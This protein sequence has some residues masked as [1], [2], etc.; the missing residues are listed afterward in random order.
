MD[1][2]WENDGRMDKHD[3][4]IMGTN[5]ETNDGTMMGK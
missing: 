1:K 2:W 5:D 3:W 4:K